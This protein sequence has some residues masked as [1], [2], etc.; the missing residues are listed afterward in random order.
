MPALLNL[1]RVARKRDSPASG[2][3]LE[4]SK[5]LISAAAGWPQGIGNKLP[6]FGKGLTEA[7]K[8]K[9]NV[10]IPSSDP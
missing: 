2:V 10:I 1:L 9:L 5:L 7:E 3:D 8:K 4:V 6:V